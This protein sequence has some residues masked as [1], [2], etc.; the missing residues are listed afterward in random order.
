MAIEYAVTV[1]LDHVPTHVQVYDEPQFDGDED[2]TLKVVPVRVSE[3]TAARIFV[4][5]TAS[6]P[7]TVRLRIY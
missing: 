2:G 7:G 6:H 1:D 3:W 5:V 4:A